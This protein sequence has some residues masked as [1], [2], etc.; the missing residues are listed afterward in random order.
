MLA[1]VGYDARANCWRANK[2]VKHEHERKPGQDGNV[3]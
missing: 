1:N 3:G 2:R